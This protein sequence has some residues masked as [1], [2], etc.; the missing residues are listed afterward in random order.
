MYANGEGVPQ[1]LVNAYMWFNLAAAQGNK[2]AQPKNAIDAKAL[3][4]PEMTSAQISQT[5]RLSRECL[6]KNYQRCGL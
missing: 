6:A 3:I 5:Q 4:A 2:L 1:N